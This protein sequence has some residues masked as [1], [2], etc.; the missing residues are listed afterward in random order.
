M[1]IDIATF[2]EFYNQVHKSIKNHNLFRRKRSTQISKWY[3]NIVHT[4]DSIWRGRQRQTFPID[5]SRKNTIYK[6]QID[7]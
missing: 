6:T 4:N 7:I 3:E 1:Y 5:P 2:I